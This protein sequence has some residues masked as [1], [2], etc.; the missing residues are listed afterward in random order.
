VRRVLI[1]TSSY[2]PA[3]LADTHR[4]RLL[5][6]DLRFFGWD[7]EILAAGVEFQRPD[8][9]ET[10]SAPFFDPTIAVHFAH[11]HWEG[12]FRLLNMRSIGWRAFLPL[13]LTGAKLLGRKTFDLVYITTTQFNL[14]LIGWL[15]RRRFGVPY[16]L[17]FH[18]PWVRDGRRNVTTK[19]VVKLF[20]SA[21]GARALERQAVCG[22][23][24][25]VSV[26][27]SYIAQLR[28]RYPRARSLSDE[29][30]TVIPFSATES[31]LASVPIKSI[32]GVT[33]EI[34]YVGAGGRIME[35]SWR[36]LLRLLSRV[37]A[38]QPQLVSR[39]RFKF[40][41]TEAFWREGEKKFLVEVVREYGLE[42]LVEEHPK[43]ISYLRAMEAIQ[44]SAGL[45]ILGVDD[46]A[47]M[48]SKLFT[49]AL[50]GKPLLV[51]LHHDSQAN[52]YFQE[53][54]GLGHLI[55]FSDETTSVPPEEENKIKTFL[56]EIAAR[57]RFDRKRELEP[58]LSPAAA[59]KHAQFFERVLST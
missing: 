12:L 23:S 43:R 31:D 51:S 38:R 22:A 9:I 2:Y 59:R 25:I 14:F 7:A 17:D 46:P 36:A 6:P 21:L 26:S 35:K 56:T 29:R 42:H 5:A 16:V 20:L 10:D 45:L 32:E 58:Y 57:K 13:Y 24:G 54:P 19:H 27:P 15:W 18:D 41:G 40:F 50:T 4:A 39:F 52:R 55:H 33:L 11:P 53:M 34:V 28:R 44:S 3:V 49:Y 47:Y 48:P 30:A 1:V 37:A 8:A